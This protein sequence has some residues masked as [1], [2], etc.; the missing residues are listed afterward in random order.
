MHHSLYPWEDSG[1]TG[2]QNT[3]WLKATAYHLRC[4]C[5]P[6]RFKWVKGHAG[7]PGN[8][9]ADQLAS[10]GANKEFPDD[11]DL[12]VPAHFQ[13][14]GL[15]LSTV[16]QVSAY[17]LI[18]GLD[19][20]PTPTRVRH[21]LERVR[22][23]VAE[24]SRKTLPDPSLWKGCRN[25]DIRR[26]VQSFLYRALND[27]L[28]ISDFWSRIPGFEQRAR[29]ASCDATIESLEHILLECDHPSTK[30]IWML[31]CHLWPETTSPWTDLSLGLLLGCGNI[32]FPAL[33]D[34]PTDKGASRLL[35]IL[36][37]EALHLVWV[38]RC[39]R[40]IQGVSHSPTAVMTRWKNKLNQ[41]ISSDR[42]LASFFE[43]KKFTRNLVH[44]T[45]T[46]VLQPFYPALD[47]DWVT[48]DEVLVGINP[49]APG[50]QVGG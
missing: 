20:P 6:T 43:H 9:A 27:A 44:H 25:P 33:D 15:R 13:P 10:L 36:L 19:R 28:R 18:S 46:P 37:S 24:V 31:T 4:R 38:L 50:F 14:T 45:W 40:T 3:K 1:W 30:L 34:R 21:L 41:R 26:P 12:T 17:A 32:V 49:T 47:P 8:E 22:L 29:C 16:T 48:K 5:A 7:N 42:F 23:S 35:R 11:I 39:E 2:V